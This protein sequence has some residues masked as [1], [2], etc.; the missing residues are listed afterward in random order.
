MYIYH[1][2]PYT[3][4]WTHQKGVWPG[5]AGIQPAAVVAGSAVVPAVQDSSVVVGSH[6]WEGVMV[7]W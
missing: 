2:I 5:P 1:L 7:D 3:C 6:Q 4:T